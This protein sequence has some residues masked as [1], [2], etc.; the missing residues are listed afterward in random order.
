MT[1]PETS[2]PDNRPINNRPFDGL[3]FDLDG[4]L[5]DT[6]RLHYESWSKLAQE[7][8]FPLTQSDYDGIRG[9]SRY[10]GLRRLLRDRELDEITSEDWL[11][12]KNNYFR[13]LMQH[14]TPSDILPGVLDWIQEA[15][16]LGM[17]V[18]LGSA[19]R[20]A[21]DVL[22]RLELDQAFD[23]I[24][25]GTTVTNIKPAPDIF[26]WVAG[27]MNV[28]PARTLIVED[29]E[30]GVLAGHAGGFRVIGVGIETLVRDADLYLPT[31]AD[32]SLEAVCQRLWR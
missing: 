13:E 30:A 16:R 1:T 22:A 11:T 14:L 23:A 17:S 10:D 32:L 24:G 26:L 3:I 20:N 5:T 25:D 31:L 27:R 4:V 19:S 29:S 9:M 28:T 7:E 21:R 2:R 15:R 8:Q 12:R 18:G 6:N